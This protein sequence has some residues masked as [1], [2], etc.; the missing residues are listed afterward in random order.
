MGYTERPKNYMKPLGEGLK[1]TKKEKPEPKPEMSARQKWFSEK[2]EDKPAPKPKAK[3]KEK[4][5]GKFSLKQSVE[6]CR[7]FAALEEIVEKNDIKLSFRGKPLELADIK[8]FKDQ[9]N[10]VLRALKKK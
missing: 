7:T 5:E 6:K 3:P 10:A 1:E 9:K 2:H 4:E 8:L